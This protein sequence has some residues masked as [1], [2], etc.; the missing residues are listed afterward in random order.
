MTTPLS[1]TGQLAMRLAR[2]DNTDEV[3]QQ[4]SAATAPHDTDLM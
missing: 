4:Q 1:R 3:V 2:S